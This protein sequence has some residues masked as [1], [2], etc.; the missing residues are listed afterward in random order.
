MFKV[1][2]YIFIK[3]QWKHG[4]FHNETLKF[5]KNLFSYVYVE[6]LPYLK[7]RFEQMYFLVHFT[8]LGPSFLLHIVPMETNYLQQFVPLFTIVV[9]SML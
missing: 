6:K 4:G 7:Y 2:F 8:M 3:I 1:G 9:V 5:L